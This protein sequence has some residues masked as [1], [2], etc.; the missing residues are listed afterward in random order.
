[1]G[2]N[3]LLE[4]LFSFGDLA[5]MFVGLGQ[6][7]GGF[8]IR[9]FETEGELE[10]GGSFGMPSAIVD[11]AEA[12]VASGAGV[13]EL[14]GFV[15]AALRGSDPLFLLGVGILAPISFR[16]GRL[17]PCRSWDRA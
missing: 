9:G 6:A 2:L 1:M 13:A 12:D 17:W 8:F 10:F 15:A 5:F 14:D 11:E 7:D 3:G 4:G 16:R